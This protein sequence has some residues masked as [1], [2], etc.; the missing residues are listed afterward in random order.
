V[1]LAELLQLLAGLAEHAEELALERQ[2][3][4]AAGKGVGA[5]LALGFVAADIL[6]HL[7]PPQLRG[8]P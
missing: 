1:D 7:Q 4:E 3:V 5:A 6:R 2:L 8:E